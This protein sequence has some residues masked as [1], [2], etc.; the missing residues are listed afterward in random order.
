[1]F[2]LELRVYEV[3]IVAKLSYILTQKPD[4]PKIA[5]F[6]FSLPCRS[7]HT[8]MLLMGGLGVLGFNDGERLHQFLFS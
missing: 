8:F 6:F 7:L 3:S 5:C 4:L 1:M 2:M